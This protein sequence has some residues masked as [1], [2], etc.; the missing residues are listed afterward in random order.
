LSLQLGHGSF[1][2]WERDFLVVV[3]VDFEH[4]P[5]QLFPTADV[6]EDLPKFLE[7]YEP[8]VVLHY[9]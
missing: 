6:S 2:F 4:D 1:E 8:I 9:Q 7:R 5:L 3:Q